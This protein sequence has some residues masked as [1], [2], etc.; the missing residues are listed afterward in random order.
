[1]LYQ[2]IEKKKVDISWMITEF[3]EIYFGGRLYSSNKKFQCLMRMLYFPFVRNALPR[4][5]VIK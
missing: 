1:M 5:Y 3:T 2:S 4:R